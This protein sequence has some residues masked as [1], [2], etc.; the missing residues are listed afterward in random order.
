M[1]MPNVAAT[2]VHRLRSRTGGCNTTTNPIA[3]TDAAMA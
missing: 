3:V 2:A 1:A